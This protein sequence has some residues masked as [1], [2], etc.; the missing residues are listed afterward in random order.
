MGV[1]R[2]D[3]REGSSYPQV[4]ILALAGHGMMEENI[5]GKGRIFIDIKE[6][7]ILI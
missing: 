4:R 6:D 7:Q 1:E 2:N 5:G 3:F